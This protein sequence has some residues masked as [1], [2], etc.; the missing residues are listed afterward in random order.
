M[1]QRPQNR[2][3]IQAGAWALILGGAMTAAVLWTNE[4]P[5]PATASQPAVT[6]PDIALVA[7]IRDFK[8]RDQ[9]G[10]HT[11]FEWEPS[12]G[13]GHYISQVADT[14]DAEQLP[15]F[16]SVGYK[17]STEWMDG[18]GRNIIRPR[19]YITARSGD[20]AGSASS[21]TGGALH[22]DTAFR[23]W[24]RDVPGVNLKTEKVLT[25]VYNSATRQYV[26]DDTIDPAFQSLGGFF[27][28]N[29]QLYGNYSSTG[30]NYHFTAML[31]TSF[32]HQA[33]AGHLFTFRG[34]DDVWVYVDGKLVIDLGGVHGAVSQTIELDRLNWL[35]N[36]QSYSLRFFFAERHTTKSNFRIETTLNL[37]D[38]TR[39]PAIKG[40]EEVEPVNEDTGS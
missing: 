28:I 6:N 25:F 15:Q 24:F 18:T 3:I 7:T 13:F 11:D 4:S 33:G 20:Q 29:G 1:N 31:E 27:P 38:A 5:K 39:R 35:V 8:G 9:S 34:D 23:Q 37:Q 30:K 26:F 21:S 36:G 17:V 32:R 22:T 2:K 14:L 19:S 10:G 16:A 12:S 40:W